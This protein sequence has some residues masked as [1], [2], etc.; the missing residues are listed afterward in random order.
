LRKA[1][2]AAAFAFMALTGVSEGTAMAAS[3]A[4]LVA[5]V[6]TM[7]EPSSLTLLGVDLASV[8][9]LL[10]IFGRRITR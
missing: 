9:L 2:F 3:N 7:S 8:G 10:F 6:I 1:F 5:L 4:P